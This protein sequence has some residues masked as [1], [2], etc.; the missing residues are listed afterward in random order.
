MLGEPDLVE[1]VELELKE[2]LDLT[3]KSGQLRLVKEIVAMANT[4]GGRILIGVTDDGDRVGIPDSDRSVWDPARI[5]DLL[6]RYINPERVEVT[7][8]FSQRGCP[9]GNVIV[10]LLVQQF[11]RPPLVIGKEGNDER[12]K[13]ILRRGM[14]LVRNNTKVEPATRADYLR[15]QKEDRK[16]IFEGIRTVVLNPGSVV[17]IANGD[18]IRDPA[19]YLLSRSVDLFRQ[20]RDKLLDGQDLLSLFVHRES[21][22]T[23]SLDRQRLI[24]HSALRRK[25]T[26]F[27]WLALLD[28]S[29]DGVL[30][31]LDE[32]LTM[33]DRD[34]SDMSGAIPL[35]AA[36]FLTPSQYEDLIARMVDSRY[37]HLRKDAKQYREHDAA[38]VAID[39]R[40][41]GSADGRPLSSL[42][43]E[44]LLRAAENEIEA[45]NSVR[46]PRRLPSIGLEYLARRLS[47]DKDGI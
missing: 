29:A 27:F 43:D 14:V 4:K 20:R 21:L 10:V 35:V 6:E 26:L 46:I 38:L 41:K 34:K 44:E 8:T 33:S 39:K 9:D 42:G 16:R 17:R 13:A 47:N 45:G 24:I 30:S 19:S 31:I 5:G 1:G 7:L 12:N 18:D 23:S 32:A 37:A 3:V 2:S 11:D 25:A 36:L 22:D 15:W 28:I 40:R